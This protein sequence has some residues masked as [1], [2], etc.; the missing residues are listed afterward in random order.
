M[1]VSQH[2]F[3]GAGFEQFSVVF[4]RGAKAFA[5]LCSDKGEI[6]FRRGAR[7]RKRTGGDVG[8]GASCGRR[9][10]QDEHDLEQRVAAEV[11]LRLEFFH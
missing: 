9:I 6:E 3:D 2:A 5:G 11:A 8:H 1:Q 7:A 10:L 4:K